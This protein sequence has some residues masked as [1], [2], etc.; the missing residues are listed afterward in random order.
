MAEALFRAH[1]AGEAKRWAALL[2]EYNMKTWSDL[3]TDAPDFAEIGKKLLLPSRP[4]VGYAFFATLRKDGA[5][6]LHPI[7]VLI[8]KDHLYVLI[9]TTSPKCADLLRDSRYALQAFPPV[10]NDENEE[11]Y[12]SGS[13]NRIQD[14]E[15]RQALIDDT[16][17]IVEE[18]EVLFELL[19][20]RAMYTKL[21]DRGTP[22]EH[23]IH[24]KWRA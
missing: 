11:F 9:P 7:S 17:V 23:P 4:Y 22:D 2:K 6:R 16:K 12:I 18:N 15:I 1:R 8:F 13:A 14:L 10:P 3:K 19:L 5:P 20:E 24:R 21:V